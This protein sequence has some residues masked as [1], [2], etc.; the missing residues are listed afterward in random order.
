MPVF[1][2]KCQA[3]P[4]Q[5]LTRLAGKR[6]LKVQGREVG[7]LTWKSDVMQVKLKQRVLDAE[8]LHELRKLQV[9]IRTASVCPTSCFC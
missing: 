8:H 1:W 5:A 2:L 3:G 7:T 6:Q 9:C 4:V